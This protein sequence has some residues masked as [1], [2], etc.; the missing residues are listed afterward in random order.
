M[1]AWHTEYGRSQVQR[2]I[3]IAI[4]H[5]YLAIIRARACFFFRIPAWRVNLVYKIGRNENMVKCQMWW[6]EQFLFMFFIHISMNTKWPNWEYEKPVIRF[7]LWLSLFITPSLL[8]CSRFPSHRLGH[9]SF[10]VPDFASIPSFSFIIFIHIGYFSSSRCRLS[11]LYAGNSDI[12]WIKADMDL[13]TCFRHESHS[14]WRWH[15]FG[16]KGQR[17]RC[18]RG[19][20]GIECVFYFRSSHFS[21]HKMTSVTSDGVKYYIFRI[22]FQRLVDIIDRPSTFQLLHRTLWP[23]SNA[24]S[25]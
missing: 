7:V 25:S 19:S 9:F 5:Y 3:N 10:V 11:S 1:H 16:A 17:S 23:M 2:Y 8:L 14:W 24:R 21:Y 13:Y 18:P 15:W 4:Y 20:S 22:L 12:W 6:N